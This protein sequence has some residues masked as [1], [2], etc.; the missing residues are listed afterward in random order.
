[1]PDAICPTLPDRYEP[2]PN[3]TDAMLG[4]GGMADVFGARDRLLGELVA[5]KVVRHEVMT[6]PEFKSR[7][8]REVDVSAAVVH[9]HLVPLHDLGELTDHRP[10]LAL[11]LANAGNLIELRRS[12][13]PW[14][15]IRRLLDEVLSALACLHARGILHLDVKLSNV[16]LHRD[17]DGRI[18]AWLSDLGLAKA[19]E[20][21]EAFQGTLAGT[22]SY[23]PLEVLLRRYAEIGPATDL[24]A[25][26]VLMYR[27]VS[28]T[29]PFKES[30]V[31]AHIS[32]RRK[33]PRNVPIRE[34]LRVPPGLSEIILTLLQADPRSRFD[35]AADVRAALAALPRL[36]DEAHI[37]PEDLGI[38]GDRLSAPPTDIVTDQE[39]SSYEH[40]FIPSAKTSDGIPPWHR[41]QPGPMPFRPPPEPGKGAK[42]R[43]SLPLFAL[44]EVPLIGRDK[45]RQALW[46]LA[47]EV[48]STG[49]PRVVLIS[50][51]AGVGKTRL[52]KST[53]RSLEEGGY[54]TC[55]DVSFS[56]GGAPGDGYLGA[57]QRLLRLGDSDPEI[58]NRRLVRWL[59]RDT[60]RTEQETRHE[61]ELLQRLGALRPGQDPVSPAVAREYLFKHLE[62]HAWRGMSVLLIED[63][64]WCTSTDDGAALAASV[65]QLGL[66]VLAIVTV[67]SDP[68]ELH[69]VAGSSIRALRALGAVEIQLERIDSDNML[70][71]VLECISLEPHLASEVVTRSQGNP[72][73]ARELLNL[74]CQ[75]DDLKPV[76]RPGN[77]PG[78]EVSEELR[79]TLNGPVE[80][81]IPDDIRAL[82]SGRLSLIFKRTDN[83]AKVG[84][85]LDVL[86]VAGSGLPWRVLE[87]AAGPGLDE[88][89]NAGLVR[90]RRAVVRLDHPLLEQLLKERV[91]GRA[92]KAAH[93][94]L[95][96]AWSR[97]AKDARAHL[98]VGRHELA[99][100]R[101][102]LAVASLVQA[103][104]GLRLS[105][106]AAEQR[107][108]ANDLADALK[109]LGQKSDPW[110]LSQL[111]LARADLASGERRASIRRIETLWSMK[112]TP[113][114]AIEVAAEYVNALEYE[115]RSRKGLPALEAIEH[116]V[117]RVQPRIRARFHQARAT[118]LLHLGRYGPAERE[119]RTALG[120]C[121]LETQEVE[122]LDMLGTCISSVDLEMGLAQLEDA[123]KKA[124]KAGFRSLQAK[125]L[126]TIARIRGIQGRWEEGR[127]M[128]EEAEQIALTIGFNSLVPLC[129]NSRAECLRFQGRVAQAEALY[130]VGGGWATATG[131]R[132]WSLAFHL[133][134]A[135]CALLRSD[136]PVLQKRLD[137]VAREHGKEWE[138]FA[139]II[140][141]LDA[142]AEVLAGHGP[143]A[144][145]S[146]PQ[147]QLLE[148]GLD[149]ALIGTIISKIATARGWKEVA[150]QWDNAVS[151]TLADLGLRAEMLSPMLHFFE[152]NTRA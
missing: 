107:S 34:G 25:L 11:A 114:M 41:P 92:K 151:T 56:R 57:V 82:L 12:N 113:A 133:N 31:P 8:Q 127:V 7:F 123:E 68:L 143:E 89:V 138:P 6:T 125:T 10:Y 144:L 14:P 106:T 2:Y 26:G 51:E 21:K 3:A 91:H 29:N 38:P 139:A 84:E 115:D 79:F 119:I 83:A 18:R 19:L 58:V 118:C 74:W 97:F 103:V 4:K 47:R 135:L 94:L 45:Q 108:A 98:E 44:R 120:Y 65:L 130:K 112:P 99:A 102:E 66:P 77:P 36:D 128:A 42:A 35:L 132:A 15:L 152:K 37:P 50:G 73:F 1:M 23:M 48:S 13:P 30:S 16:L 76:V 126:A 100:G 140:S 5:I 150:R 136:L 80:G 67:R 62:T 33:P 95:A 81:A 117:A 54:A 46:D 20:Q 122:L 60:R 75:G 63:A 39:I 55:V 145:S 27:L 87:N 49:R 111:S 70:D 104:E 141:G 52:L 71:L 69:P 148:E 93:A 146:V 134:L 64:Q 9:P 88:L 105:G 109:P 78:S 110:I 53:M 32:K 96:R 101:L 85:A 129:R 124:K 40:D 28:G 137:I 121:D 17:P 24:F 61:A 22:L 116:F 72:F 86:G 43:A 90:N 149:G 142:A 131:Q 147:R 59:A